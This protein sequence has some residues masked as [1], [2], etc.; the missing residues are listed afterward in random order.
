MIAYTLQ[1]NITAIIILLIV[2]KGAKKHID[3]SRYRDRIFMY[4]L[5][6]NALILAIDSVSIL[7]YDV[8]GQPVHVIQSL[9]KMTFY[10]LNPLPG[11]LWILYVYDFIFHNPEGLNR[12]F[13]IGIIPILVNAVLAVASI[14][15]GYLFI[16][17]TDNHYQ[18]GEWFLLM[19]FFAFGYTIIAFVVILLNRKR[20]QRQDWLPLLTFAIPPAIGGFLQTYFYGL[21]VLWPSLTVSLL[22]IYVFIQSKTINTDF[23][24]GLNNRR[25]FDYYLEDWR[26]WQKDGKKVAGFMMDMDGFKA[27][28]DNYGHQIGDQALIEM[29]R[30]LR[31]SFS[32]DDFLARL[33]G[34]EFAAIVEVTDPQEIENIRKR[35]DQKIECFNQENKASY[36]LSISC[37]SGIFS[38]DD[39]ESLR[40]FFAELDKWMYEEKLQR[41]TIRMEAKPL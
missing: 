25:E 2:Y 10:I 22:I 20:I 5:Y 39:E 17:S 37:G 29:S 40:V 41:K 34:D 8:P 1:T 14:W 18:R 27:I 16:L 30:I 15:G 24:T 26:K 3:L 33:G 32:R 4:L 28:N 13:K 19:P 11:F 36:Q 31:E 12:L 7:F 6:V 9:L 35:L 38:P 23:L 21:V